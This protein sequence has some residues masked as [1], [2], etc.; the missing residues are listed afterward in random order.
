MYERDDISV[1]PQPLMVVVRRVLGDD[2]GVYPQ[3][4]K[5]E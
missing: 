3:A 2:D 5:L 4:L 1:D